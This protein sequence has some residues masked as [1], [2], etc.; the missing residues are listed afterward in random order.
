MLVAPG[1]GPEY[2]MAK[3]GLIVSA[4]NVCLPRLLHFERHPAAKEHFARAKETTQG[5]RLISGCNPARDRVRRAICQQAGTSMLVYAFGAHHNEFV[6][7][8]S[9]I[10]PYRLRLFAET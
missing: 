9:M 4:L 6:A 5:W 7:P 2:E 3:F 8:R 10:A 1:E